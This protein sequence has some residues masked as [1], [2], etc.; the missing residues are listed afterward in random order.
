MIRKIIQQK[1]L[2]ETIFSDLK[3]LLKSLYTKLGLDDQV[4]RYR[5]FWMRNL[6]IFSGEN[7]YV[8]KIFVVLES[9]SEP[10]Y[11]LGKNFIEI[12]VKFPIFWIKN[13]FDQFSGL[14]FINNNSFKRISLVNHEF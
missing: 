9:V 1:N 11:N 12:Q 4:R 13:L 6:G 2:Y 10:P 3:M 7:K 8:S 5:W 14:E